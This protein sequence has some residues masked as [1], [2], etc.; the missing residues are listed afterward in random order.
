MRCYLMIKKP[1]PTQFSDVAAQAGLIFCQLIDNVVKNSTEHFATSTLLGALFSAAY[2][3]NL[4]GRR[5]R[6]PCLSRAAMLLTKK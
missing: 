4:K 3:P 5:L 1:K 6:C 2:A